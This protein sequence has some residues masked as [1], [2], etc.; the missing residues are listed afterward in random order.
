MTS[1]FIEKVLRDYYDEKIPKIKISEKY[2][3]SNHTIIKII[4]ENE[5]GFWDKIPPRRPV[6]KPI[7]D[8][9]MILPQAKRME[10]LSIDATAVIELTFQKIIDLL[11]D[12]KAVLSAGQLSGFIA[13]AGPYVMAKVEGKKKEDIATN[14]KDIFKMFKEQQNAKAN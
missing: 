8:T 1:K 11:K 10:L 3:C 2:K 14:K 4:K 9:R 5:Y 13:S 7:S 6:D 12:D